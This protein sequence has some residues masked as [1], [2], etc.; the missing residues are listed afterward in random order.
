MLEIS[1][2]TQY[3]NRIYMCEQIHNIN[4]YKTSQCKN[5]K[6]RVWGGMWFCFLCVCAATGGTSDFI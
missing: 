1:T 5:K 2:L 3:Q 4:E 6:G